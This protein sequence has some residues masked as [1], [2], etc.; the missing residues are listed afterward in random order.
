MLDPYQVVEARAMGADCILLIMAVLS[1]AEATELEA[2]A[3]EYQMDVLAEVHDADELGRATRLQTRL[4]GINN[5][6]LK[7]LKTDLSVTEELGRHVPE[8]CILVS[9]SGIHTPAD[10]ARLAKVGS[11]CFLVGE[12]L[13]RQA[14]V[15][16][17]TR[18]LL[19]LA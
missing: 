13:M 2:V 15:E 16:M 14:D 4:I 17:A 1:D 7:T 9:E 6:N 8:G 5:R 3:R 18:K 12:S 19:T 11:R 10:L